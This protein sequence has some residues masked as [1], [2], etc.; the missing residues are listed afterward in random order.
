MCVGL[1][2]V[3]ELILPTCESCAN[4][5]PVGAVRALRHDSGDRASFARISGYVSRY[6]DT[7]DFA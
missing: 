1:V 5:A 6:S 3:G 4:G 7:F 2:S